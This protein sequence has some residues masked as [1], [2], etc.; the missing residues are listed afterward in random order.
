MRSIWCD[1]KIKN[2]RDQPVWYVHPWHVDDRLVPNGRIEVA[3]SQ[4]LFFE[5]DGFEIKNGYKSQTKGNVGS[6]V[7]FCSLAGNQSN[8]SSFLRNSAARRAH[9]SKAMNLKSSIKMSTPLNSAKYRTITINSKVPLEKWVPF[10]TMAD[11]V[12]RMKNG[13]IANDNMNFDKKTS[14]TRTGL[15]KEAVRLIELD[16]LNS[17]KVPIQ[18][19]PPRRVEWTDRGWVNESGRPR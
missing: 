19:L 18:K 1:L 11:K 7:R 4:P 13:T 5:G 15:R 14:G 6:F 9:L 16:I 10:A 12:V 2:R 8:S 3:W 17:R